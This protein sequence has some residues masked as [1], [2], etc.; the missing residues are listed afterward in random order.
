MRNT[1]EILRQKWLLERPHR[2]VCASVGVSMGAVSLALKRAAEAKLTWEA[3]Q[4]LDDGEL[5]ARLYP[6]VAVAGARAEPD[7]TWIHRERH[8]PGVTLELLHHEYLAKH[9]DGLRYTTFCDRYRAWLGRRG[10]VMRQMHV[11][12]DKLFVDYSGKKAHIVDA[13]TGE[14]TDVELFVAALGASNLTYAEATYTQR[15]PDWIASHVRA[16]EHFGGVP[17]ALVPDQLKSGVT[18][19]CLYEPEVQRT[20]EELAQHYGTTVLPARPAHPRD[21]G[22][23]EV[24]VQIAQR[25]LLAR[26]RDEVFHSLGA[27]NAR[28]HELLVDLNGREMRRY[29]KSRRALFDAIE[30]TALRP[31]PSA[32]FEYADWRK[33]RVN[34]DYHV[35]VDGHLY[36]VPYR[37]VHEAVE[38]RLTADVVEILHGGMRVAAH[39]RSPVKGGF[40]TLTE[41]MPS[42]HRAHAE[43]TPSRI[44]AWAGK[45]GTATHA[46]CD[47]ILADRPHPEQGFRSC[48]GILRLGKRYGEARLEAACLRALGVRARSYRHVESIL[49]NGLDR[50]VATD[51][52]SSPSLTHENV[53]G[54]DYYH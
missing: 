39:R 45:V 4:A 16:F 1:R 14:V 36:S 15:G 22:K 24:A 53:R 26:I 29:G 8:R 32:R 28:L 18:R 13:A 31:L 50:V 19:A 47:A 41:H 43:W 37:L 21:K 40:T 42:A 30:R 7:C 35:A 9:P 38:A 49:K 44:L 11:A 3:V 34:I 5:E 17:A 25:W 2:A 51:P 20:Y 10:L 6:H 33:A 46:L 52:S 23:V 48:L 12:G 54:R 27:L